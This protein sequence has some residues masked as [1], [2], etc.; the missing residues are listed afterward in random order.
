MPPWPR[1]P[2]S[3]CPL[4]QTRP[5]CG[6]PGRCG[7]GL[8]RGEIVAQVSAYKFPARRVNSGW[9]HVAQGEIFFSE[10]DLA[11]TGGVQCFAMYL[12]HISV[13][14]RNGTV[15]L[16]VRVHIIRPPSRTVLKPCCLLPLPCSYGVIIPDG[17]MPLNKGRKALMPS[18][19]PI[20][21]VP[22]LRTSSSR[23]VS[24]L[25]L[26]TQTIP[27]SSKYQHGS[28]PS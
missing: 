10:L 2:A 8:V 9:I 17:L 27:G 4:K 22:P 15:W 3:Y 13:S 28:H 19:K 16:V 20:I 26:R 7:F 12:I 14:P 21:R 1:N 5:S 11:G 25:R 23:S 6:E 24:S 18:R